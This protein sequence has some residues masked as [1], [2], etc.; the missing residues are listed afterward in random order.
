M[1]V[2]ADVC[3]YI[4]NILFYFVVARLYEYLHPRGGGGG[5]GGGGPQMK[6]G[7]MLL[8]PCGRKNKSHGLSSS[9]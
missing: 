7:G 9:V 2:Q 1:C 5:G 4:Y 3:L 6:N 8:A